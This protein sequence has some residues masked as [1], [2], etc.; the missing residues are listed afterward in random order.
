MMNKKNETMSNKILIFEYV[1]LSGFKEWK[2]CRNRAC[3]KFFM[4][5]FLV[6][7]FYIPYIFIG[8]LKN[9]KKKIYTKN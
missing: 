1:C 4:K 8:M 9:T 5:V 6:F 2:T 3:P 7:F